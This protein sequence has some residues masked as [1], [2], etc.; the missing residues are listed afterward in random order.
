MLDKADSNRNP[1]NVRS[2]LRTSGG[3]LSDQEMERNIKKKKQKS[4]PWNIAIKNIILLETKEGRPLHTT[5]VV[6]SFLKF[7]LRADYLLIVIKRLE[8]KSR[9]NNFRF[10]DTRQQV[11]TISRQ[12]DKSSCPINS[13]ETSPKK[14]RISG[15]FLFYD[16]FFFFLLYSMTFPLSK[17]KESFFLTFF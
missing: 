1:S 4:D 14:K 10:L 17:K 2:Y 8:K 9:V 11:V 12:V 16:I 13:I 6:F 5:Q 7:L 15:R 3:G